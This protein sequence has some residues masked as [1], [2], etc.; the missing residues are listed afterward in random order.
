MVTPVFAVGPGRLT[1]TLVLVAVVMGVAAGSVACV[2]GLASGRGHEHAAAGPVASAHADHLA[3]GVDAS[4]E[5]GVGSAESDADGRAA[6][7][8]ADHPGMSCVVEVDLRVVGEQ[9]A[10]I[11]DRLDAAVVVAHA[12]GTDGPEPPVPRTS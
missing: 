11:C 12:D 5:A 2:A 6:T 10:T 1:R 9:Y 7:P 3:V 8:A 4:A